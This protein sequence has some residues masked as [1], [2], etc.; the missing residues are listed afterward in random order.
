ML[1]VLTLFS[2]HASAQSPTASV[3]T[4]KDLLG[5]GKTAAAIAVLKEVVGQSPDDYQA[6]F[7]LGV[8]QSK[9]HQLNESATS[10]RKV[11]KL[12]PNLAEPHN[13]LAVIYNELGDLRAAVQELETSLSINPDYG[14]IGDSI[15]FQKSGTVYS[16]IRSLMNSCQIHITP[17]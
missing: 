8:S 16:L 9:Q 13:N 5:Q 6:W 14:E 10:F 2:A 3:A 7:L 4:A 1:L 15:F 11:A 12:R 17:S